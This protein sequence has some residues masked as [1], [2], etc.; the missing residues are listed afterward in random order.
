[1][2]QVFDRAHEVRSLSL[3]NV[4]GLFAGVG[5]PESEDDGTWPVGSTYYRSDGT[6]YQKTA[7]PT[8]WVANLAGAPGQNALGFGEF[9]ID[10]NGDL[11]LTYA[12]IDVVEND[13]SINAQG[14]LEITVT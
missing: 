12:G 14:E 3:N 1:M 9:S 4:V 6:S 7:M 13:F 5:T 10:V 11:L 8:T 2:P